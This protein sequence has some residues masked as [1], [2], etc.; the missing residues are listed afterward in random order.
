M[1]KHVICNQPWACVPRLIDGKI[2]RLLK[3]YFY[4][5]EG[6]F[7]LMDSDGITFEA[8]DVF[9]D[10]DHDDAEDVDEEFMAGFDAMRHDADH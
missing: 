6:H 8:P 10:D 3:S 7:K 4:N 9:F 1:T 5:G 2:Y